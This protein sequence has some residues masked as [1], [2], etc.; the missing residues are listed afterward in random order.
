VP[1]TKPACAGELTYYE[2][3]KKGQLG[4]RP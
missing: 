3:S 4:C 1:D 2:N